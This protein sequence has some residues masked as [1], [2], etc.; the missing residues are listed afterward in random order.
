MS[1]RI[2]RTQRARREKSTRKKKT[3][4][5]DRGDPQEREEAVG[6]RHEIR[7]QVPLVLPGDRLS[8]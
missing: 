6:S 3:S 5:N 7:R 4:S 8:T 2:G 1:I